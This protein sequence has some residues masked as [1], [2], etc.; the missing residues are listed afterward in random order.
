MKEQIE[1]RRELRKS[2]EAGILDMAKALEKRGMATSDIVATIA[3]VQ[4]IS[5]TEAQKYYD[6]LVVTS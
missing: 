1:R 3:D 6:R 2:R 4:N 5:Q